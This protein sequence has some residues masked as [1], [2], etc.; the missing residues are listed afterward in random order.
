MPFRVRPLSPYGN[1]GLLGS[2]E[3]ERFFPR[4]AGEDVMARLDKVK[5]PLRKWAGEAG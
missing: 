5:A 2:E 4:D 3:G 1:G